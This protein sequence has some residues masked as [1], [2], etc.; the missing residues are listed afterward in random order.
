MLNA[1]GLDRRIV[2]HRRGEEIGRDAF[3]APIFGSDVALTVSAA[4]RPLSDSERMAASE[5]G[6][7]MT[8]RLQIRWSADVAALSPLWWLTFDG[9]TFDIVG[10]KEIG[11]REGIEITAAAR[12]E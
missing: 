1:G 4:F 11:R 2:L 3:N 9:R 8:A 7:T 12:A 6:A 5:V 10:V